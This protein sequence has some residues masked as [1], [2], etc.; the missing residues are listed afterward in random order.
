MYN[1]PIQA[2][3]DVVFPTTPGAILKVSGKFLSAVI[4][5]EAGDNKY[6]KDLFNNGSKLINN[7]SNLSRRAERKA[8]RRLKTQRNRYL[9]SSL[10]L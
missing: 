7:G 6:C 8:I 4:I 3:L 2:R 9:R 10:A 5:Q 1:A